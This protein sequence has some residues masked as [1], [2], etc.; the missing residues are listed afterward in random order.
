MKKWN[1]PELAELDIAMTENGIPWW[2]QEVDIP[3]YVPFVGYVGD[4]PSMGETENCGENPGKGQQ[5]TSGTGDATN[6]L[7]G[8]TTEAVL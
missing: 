7:S 2:H 3:V 8:V 1:T 5:H 6:W 4:V